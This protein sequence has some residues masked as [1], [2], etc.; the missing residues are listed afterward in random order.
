MT[1]SVG[2]EGVKEMKEKYGMEAIKRMLEL[3]GRVKE[4]IHFWTEWWKKV[5]DLDEVGGE[6]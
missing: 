3:N 2:K 1:L 6:L 4:N 5:V